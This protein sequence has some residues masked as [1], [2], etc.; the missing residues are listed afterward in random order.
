MIDARKK[1]SGIKVDHSM[2][3][4][5]RSGNPNDKAAKHILF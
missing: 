1:T 4:L 3:I 2:A 5:G